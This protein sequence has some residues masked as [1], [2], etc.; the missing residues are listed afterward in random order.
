M[1]PLFPETGPVSAEGQ[2]INSSKTHIVALQSKTFT[3]VVFY[4]QKKS[5]WKGL[6]F[7]W[8]EVHS[9]FLLREFQIHPV[10]GL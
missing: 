8:R 10:S 7:L 4:D 6:V 3:V 9:W 1:T 2:H 5:N